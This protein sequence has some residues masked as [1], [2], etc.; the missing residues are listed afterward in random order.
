[1]KKKQ[2]NSGRRKKVKSTSQAIACAKE[3]PVI[4]I[5]KVVDKKRI[6]GRMEG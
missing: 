3:M 5:N 2:S 6:I 4:P 1:V